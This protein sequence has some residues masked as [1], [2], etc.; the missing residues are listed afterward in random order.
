M[1]L[2]V[3]GLG[4]GGVGAY[5]AVLHTLNN[6]LAKGMIFLAVGNVVFATGTSDADAIRG[7]LRRMPASAILL[8][9]G[10]FA[11]TGSPPF[12]M[13]ISE[14]TILSAAIG[15]H[16]PWVAGIVLL[17]LAI[18]FVGIAAMILEMVYG[19][20]TAARPAGAPSEDRTWRVVAP[21][22]LAM[23]VLGLGIYLPPALTDAL[24]S[25]A[26]TL[27]GRAP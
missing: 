7:L 26:A 21:A 10:L 8:I 20:P 14:F 25:A 18:I 24:T 11:V 23:L 22:A 16:H 19:E 4:L 15:E 1:G 17:L 9:V 12:G 6:G 3:L 13:F 27:G 5:G 2:L